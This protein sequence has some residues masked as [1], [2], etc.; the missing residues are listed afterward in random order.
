MKGQ[1][2]EPSGDAVPRVTG[3]FIYPVK[4]ARG[5]ALR[6]AEVDELGFRDDRRYM[7]VD[8]SGGFVS[9][10]SQPR[11]ALIRPALRDGMLVLQAPGLGSLALPRAGINGVGDGARDVPGGLR[12]RV[13]NDDVA[14]ESAGPEAER[15]ITAFL[16]APARIVRLAAHAR[17]PVDP[18]YARRATDRVAFVDG[19]PCLLISQGSLDGLNVRLAEPVPMDRFRPNL[20]VG[21]TEPHAEDGWRRIRVGTAM[22]DVVKPCGRCAVTTVDQDRALPGDEPLR[23]LATYRKVG[24]KVLFGQNLIHEGPAR[25]AVGDKVEVLA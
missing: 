20:V 15:W 10:R 22:F 12:V 1:A 4:G 25:L 11:L 7:I 19:Y 21:G 18:R 3:L 14:A 6:A 8:P 17:R 9:Q 23:T 24:S 13:W 2:L 16:G 5:V